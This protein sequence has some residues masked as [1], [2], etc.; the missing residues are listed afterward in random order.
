ML[1]DAYILSEPLNFVL[2]LSGCSAVFLV[3]LNA[4]LFGVS[5]GKGGPYVKQM[6]ACL[7]AV[8]VFVLSWI[9]K[10]VRYIV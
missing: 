4:V 5:E 10:I 6:I 9:A 3:L 1:A 2:I 7:V 8:T